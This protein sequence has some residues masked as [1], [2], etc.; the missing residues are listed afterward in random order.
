[1]SYP[2]NLGLDLME[3]QGNQ[4]EK[5]DFVIFYGSYVVLGLGKVPFYFHGRR[6]LMAN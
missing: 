4:V 6:G 2:L 3:V 5:R 1:M